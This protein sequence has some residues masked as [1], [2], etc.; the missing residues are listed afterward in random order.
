MQ[1]FN[2]DN[3]F[4]NSTHLIVLKTFLEL[5][6]S[7]YQLLCSILLYANQVWIQSHYNNYLNIPSL[8][9]S[10]TEDW[11]IIVVVYIHIYM[12]VLAFNLTATLTVSVM[13]VCFMC[14]H[15][16]LL[17]YIYCQT[18]IGYL[19]YITPFGL[20]R[21]AWHCSP[22][23]VYIW[24]DS[25]LLVWHIHFLHIKQFQDHHI[26]HD[27]QHYMTCQ[28]PLS[29]QTTHY[30]LKYKWGNILGLTSLQL[31]SQWGESLMKMM[32]QTTMWQPRLPLRTLFCH[33]QRVQMKKYSCTNSRGPHFRTYF[34]TGRSN[35]TR[36]RGTP[37]SM[38]QTISFCFT[39]EMPSH[40]LQ[41]AH[42]PSC[43]RQ[44]IA[45]HAA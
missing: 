15:G 17:L 8:M 2:K 25:T 19:F 7:W 43:H 10:A 40:W 6:W 42:R 16:Y 9:D 35:A 32:K 23:C 41:V 28:C 18:V 39:D 26:L 45:H 11:G 29:L 37:Y 27:H 4:I 21:G 12:I 30:S 33:F 34:G 36:E 22:Q 13:H 5:Y 24:P 44:T 38:S 31:M 3:K 1:N 14:A 20:F